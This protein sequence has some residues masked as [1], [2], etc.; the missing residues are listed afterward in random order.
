MSSGE[1]FMYGHIFHPVTGELLAEVNGTLTMSDGRGY[2]V[3]GNKVLSETGEVLA[4]LSVERAP[5]GSISVPSKS[6]VN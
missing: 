5:P 3:D 6:R 2:K 1:L 4:Y